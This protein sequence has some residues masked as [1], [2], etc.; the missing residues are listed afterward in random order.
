MV[1]NALLAAIKIYMDKVLRLRTSDVKD[2]D[3]QL[4]LAKEDAMKQLI[5]HKPNAGLIIRHLNDLRDALSKSGKCF[6][7]LK[8]RTARK[9]ISGWSPLYFITEVPMSWDMVLDVPYIEGSAIKGVIRDYFM[10]VVKELTGS[11]VEAKKTTDCVFGNNEMAG[12]V[13]FFNAYPVSSDEILTYDII[14]PHKP[15]AETDDVAQ[16]TPNA[17]LRAPHYPKVETEYNV[18][19]VPVKFLAIKEGVEFVTFLA[20]DKE[21]LSKSCGDNALNNLLKALLL[22]MKMGWGRRT[23]RGYG[24]LEIVSREVVLKCPGSSS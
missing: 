1:R 18:T 24:E 21:E 8:F 13:I 10:E 16:E 17:Y 2:L 9:F 4:R 20:F 6:I 7:E 23:S 19:P 3:S 15:K 14:T 11:D 12:K 22:S 5:Y